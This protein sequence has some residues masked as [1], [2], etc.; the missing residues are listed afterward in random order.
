MLS[1]GINRK[2]INMALL[3][4][5]S[6]FC[7]NLIVFL[8]KQKQSTEGKDGQKLTITIKTFFGLEKILQDELIELGYTDVLLLNRAVQ[9]SGSWED[10]YF[11]NYNLRCAISV[12][13][14]IASFE[15]KHPDDLYKNCLKIDWTSYFNVDKTFA[16]K[17]AVFTE[18]YKHSQFPFLVVKDAI[19]D[20]FR[21][22]SGDRPDVNVKKP[23]VLFDLYIRNNS[24][25]ISLNTSGAPLFQRGYRQE[26]GL[27]PL[28]EVLAAALIRISGWDRK[29]TFFDPFCGSGTFL[30][31]AALIAAGIPPMV[32]RQ[33]FAFKN[34]ANYRE[35]KW[36][37]ITANVNTKMAKLPCRI[38]GSD[39]SAEMVTKTRR[40]LRG[41]AIGR[42][43]ETSVESFKDCK[44]PDEKGLM[45]SNPP[46]GERM[47]EEIEELYAEIGNWM[48]KEMTGFD[49]WILSSNMDAFKFIGLKPDL[50]IK[51]YN[52]DLECSFRKYSIFEGSQKDMKKQQNQENE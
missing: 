4:S 15:L 47:G 38:L 10:V 35:E 37:E 43:I 40:N 41:L 6:F 3:P 14:E 18:L 29:S 50:K 16:V 32:E 42:F 24:V 27:A 48:K 2:E 12:L 20:T 34:F 46:Y 52:G 36:L 23:Q 9:I 25:T 45:I 31:E 44:K 33:H 13:V 49:C 8:L 30:I 5:I 26:A 22:V 1:Q 39:I 17:G 11:L 21:K 51:V 19:V 7:T 28:N